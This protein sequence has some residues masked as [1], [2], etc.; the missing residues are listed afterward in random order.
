MIILLTDYFMKKIILIS[1]FFMAFSVR[2]LAQSSDEKPINLLK[3]NLTG[4]ILNNYTFQYERSLKK[5]ISLALSFRFMPYSSLPIK[6]IVRDALGNNNPDSYGVIDRFKVSNISFTPEVRFYKG[7]KV[8]QGFYLA[9]FY[10]F[11]RFNS[12]D[13][14]I[15]YQDKNVINKVDTIIFKGNLTGN[16]IGIMAGVQ[17][18]IKKHFCIDLNIAGPH[19]GISNGSFSG[20][21][22]YNLTDADKSEIEKQINNLNIPLTKISYDYPSH[23]IARLKFSGPWG[24]I[25]AGLSIGVKF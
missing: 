18:I 24:G 1:C 15:F 25:R 7:K 3:L 4:I 12:N 17:W 11:V 21:T 9:P 19:F 14:L 16:S 8:G 10:R 22:D 13:L 2:L 6:G 20:T 23:K 5:K